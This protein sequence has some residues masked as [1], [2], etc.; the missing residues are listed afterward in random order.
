MNIKEIREIINLMNENALTE[1]E[2][3]REGLRIRLRKGG[4]TSEGIEKIVMASPQIQVQATEAASELKVEKRGIE[5]RAPMVGTFYRAPSPDAPPFV[6][7]GSAI[8][9]GQVVCIIEAMKLMNE[10]KSEVKGKI[11]EVLVENGD[12]VEF[13]TV[14]FLVA[15]S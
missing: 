8:E 12:P 3:E 2:L 11:L 5:I 15:P 1:F 9:T 10:I 4:A 6:E 13:G 14:L 7:T